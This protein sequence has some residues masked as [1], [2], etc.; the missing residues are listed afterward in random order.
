[1]M[2]SISSWL[3]KRLPS[4]RAKTIE[5]AGSTTSLQENESVLDGLLRAGHQIPY[6]C[7]GGSC[8]SCMMQCTQGDIPAPAQQGLTAAQKELGYFLACSCTPQSAM[9]VALKPPAEKV[10]APIIDKQQLND[11]VVQLRVKA[12]LAY[13]AGQFVKLFRNGVVS[14]S[15]SLASVAGI[16]DYLEFHIKRVEGGKFSTWAYD[17]LA[18]GDEIALE[19]PSGECFYSV[20]DPQQ[21][22]LLAGLGTG[23]APL[24]GIVRDALLNHQHQGP[25]QLVIG[26]RTSEQL[27]LLSELQALASSHSNLTVHCIAQHVTA[28]PRP[29]EQA[30]IYEF[31]QQLVPD[32]K[33][34]KVF[35]CGA[36]S[37]VKKLKKQCFLAG[38]NMADISADAFVANG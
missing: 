15:Y 34:Y 31:C 30:N 36:D 21:P 17:E 32:C 22:M 33:G 2:S 1:M 14:R 4:K 23:L 35:L 37:F 5:F 20:T 38:A 11:D 25:I 7:R 9:A 10:I 19:G 3:T 28:A 16:D 6:G 12:E 8:Q 13:R 27:Y 26:A 18:I 24:Y 29:I